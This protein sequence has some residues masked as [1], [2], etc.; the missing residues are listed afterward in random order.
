MFF[1]ELYLI[2][3]KLLKKIKENEFQDFSKHFI[4]KNKNDLNFMVTTHENILRMWERENELNR[5]KK[6]YF[7]LNTRK[8]V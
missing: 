1:L 5:L 3:R 8:V 6:I 2:N 4:R 7:Q